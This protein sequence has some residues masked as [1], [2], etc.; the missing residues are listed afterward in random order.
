VRARGCGAA[1]RGISRRHGPQTLSQRCKEALCHSSSQ[2]D[3]PTFPAV[4]NAAQKP[5]IAAGGGAYIGSLV[6]AMSRTRDTGKTGH[7]LPFHEEA[8]ASGVLVAVHVSPD[9][10]LDAARVLREA[11][12]ATIEKATGPWQQGRWADFDPTR[13]PE[14]LNE[15]SQKH[16]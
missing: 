1:E 13:T 9:N 14:P 4:E 6:G 11:G 3:S 8:R 10:E 12:G 15:Y 7:H 5:L 2:Q 16:A